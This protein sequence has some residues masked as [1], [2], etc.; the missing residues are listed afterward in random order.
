MSSKRLIIYGE[1]RIRQPL[2]ETDTVVE[3]NYDIESKCKEIH[4]VTIMILD[5]YNV[6]A[7][8]VILN[9]TIETHDFVGQTPQRSHECWH[10]LSV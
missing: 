1:L 6:E 2:V 3:P 10:L 7:H 8:D 9:V 5:T 4:S